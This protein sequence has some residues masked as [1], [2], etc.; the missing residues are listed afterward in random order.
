MMIRIAFM[1]EVLRCERTLHLSQST[2]RLMLACRYQAAPKRANLRC[3]NIGHSIV[4]M[5]MDCESS[6]I[7]CASCSNVQALVEVHGH[8][9]VADS[10]V[11][12]LSSLT[13]QQTQTSSGRWKSCVACTL[14]GFAKCSSVPEITWRPAGCENVKL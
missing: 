6:R 12:G 8:V 7:K 2:L 13:C 4:W 1:S 10:C 5:E 3:V 11:Q 14:H 9:Y